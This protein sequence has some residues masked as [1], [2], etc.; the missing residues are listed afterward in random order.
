MST[1][2]TADHLAQLEDLVDE[3]LTLP[4]IADMWGCPVADLRRLIDDAELLGVKR[5][6]PKVLS[7]PAALVKPTLV[8]RLAGTITV[9]LDGGFSPA[10]ALIWLLSEDDSL[11]EAPIVSLRA[12]KRGEIRRRAQ[13]LAF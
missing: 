10:E 1:D 13:A 5:G 7:V 11:G 2:A 3:W 12:G 6:S 9:L 8:E 4:D